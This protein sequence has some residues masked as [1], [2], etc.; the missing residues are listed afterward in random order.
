MS[1]SF[2]ALKDHM[3]FG[4]E[5][6]TRTVLDMLVR[7]VS[8]VSFPAYPQT[9]LALR[10]KPDYVQRALASHQESARKGRPLTVSDKIAW[11]AT[12]RYWPG[13]TRA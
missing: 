4:T 5:P 7:E 6:P 11:S 3:D 12:R 1:F 13:K 10:A 8:P 2:R 9:E